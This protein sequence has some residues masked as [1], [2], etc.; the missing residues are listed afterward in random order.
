MFVTDLGVQVK[1]AAARRQGLEGFWVQSV[2]LDFVSGI[3][4]LANA[5]LCAVMHAGET[6]VD[7]RKAGGDLLSLVVRGGG[8]ELVALTRQPK[9]GRSR[10]RVLRPCFR[11]PLLPQPRTPKHA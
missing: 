3:F 10:H 9:D 1:A 8:G 2:P 11:V 4:R 5:H 7:V 6:C